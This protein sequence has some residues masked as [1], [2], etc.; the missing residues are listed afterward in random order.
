MRAPLCSVVIPAYK[1]EGYIEA[2]IRSAR[3]QTMADIEILVIDD[4]SPDGT[5]ALVKGFAV[6]DRRIR[7]I[8]QER[9]G[10]VAAARNR[11]IQEAKSEWIAFLDSDDMWKLDK[12]E[13]QFALQAETGAELIY[14]GAQCIDKE[15]E[16]LNRMFRV[17]AG[18]TYAGQLKGN[19]IV[20]SSVLVRRELLMRYPMERSDLHEDYLCWLRLL[21]AGCRAAG[22]QEPVTLYRLTPG[23][24]SRNKGRAIKMTWNTWKAAGEPLHRRCASFLAYAFHGVK[25]YLL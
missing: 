4:C 13:K 10:G 16:L 24:K 23:S 15:G 1:S 17:P 12:L 22:L 3:E 5:G 21:K 11:G 6:E 20:C 18:A 14:T 25:R 8:G 9:N 19:D 7:Y 2:C